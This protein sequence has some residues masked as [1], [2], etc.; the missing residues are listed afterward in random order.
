MRRLEWK[1]TYSGDMEAYRDQDVKNG[2]PWKGVLIMRSA[3][4]ALNRILQSAKGS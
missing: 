4:P 3:P 1:R 2:V